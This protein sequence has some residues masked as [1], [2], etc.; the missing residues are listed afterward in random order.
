M[1][2]EKPLRCRALGDHQLYEGR[3]G[4]LKALPK[5]Y[6]RLTIVTKPSTDLKAFLG[7]CASALNAESTETLPTVI[8]DVAGVSELKSLDYIK[9]T[10][11]LSSY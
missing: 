4:L 1:D 9:T 8:K 10:K 7:C 11:L 2:Q 5:F 3:P 6:W